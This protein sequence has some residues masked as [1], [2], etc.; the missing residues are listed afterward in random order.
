MQY[1]LTGEMRLSSSLSGLWSKHRCHR[2]QPWQ[3]PL[4]CEN[5]QPHLI[6]GETGL[7]TSIA[8]DFCFLA[9]SNTFH[10][11]L[12]SLCLKVWYSHM[13][14]GKKF[15]CPSYSCLFLRGSWGC[16][17]SPRL[18]WD[19]VDHRAAQGGGEQ[20]RELP[21]AHTHSVHSRNW[22][23]IPSKYCITKLI[24]AFLFVPQSLNCSSNPRMP[25]IGI[26]YCSESAVLFWQGAL[27]MVLLGSTFTV[28]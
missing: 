18:G 5:C 8:L 2:T 27:E 20:V 11:E 13:L 4:Q 1:L 26:S 22:I 9:F 14:S 10:T 28:S 16:S 3:A 21:S 25:L 15:L 12:Y 17:V 24:F 7:K 19:F 6:L 23:L